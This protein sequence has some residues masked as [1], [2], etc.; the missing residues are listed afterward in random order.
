MAV[1]KKR[2]EEVEIASRDDDR[3]AYAATA[4]RG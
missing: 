4:T 1:D 3:S 2:E